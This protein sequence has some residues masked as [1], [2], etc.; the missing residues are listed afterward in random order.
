MDRHPRIQPAV[1]SIS[2]IGPYEAKGPGDTPSR[3]R[4][5]VCQ[6]ARPGEEEGCAKTHSCHADA[7]GLSAAGD[8]CGPCKC[9]WSSTAKRGRRETLTRASKWPC[10]AVLVS[11][12]VSVPRR[13]RSGRRR[14]EHRLSH[15]RSGAG[16][17]PVV[18]SVEQ[19][20]GRRAAR[21]WRLPA[22]SKEPAVLEQQVRRMLA[23]SRSQ[24]LVSNFAEQWLHLRNLASITPDM[25]LFPGLRRQSAAGVSPGNGALLRKHPARGSE[26]ARSAERELHVR[27]RTAGQALRHPECVRQPVPAHHVGRGQRRAAGCC[28]RE[29]F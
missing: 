4:I 29:A 21:T 1:Y 22:N 19:H 15:Q 10:R 17:P 18:L 2:I 3:R 20:S 11:P 12:R 24:A 25:R 13:A 8:R 26:R 28:A 27:Q 7:P 9:R 16:F 6:P 5:F 23:D 14:A